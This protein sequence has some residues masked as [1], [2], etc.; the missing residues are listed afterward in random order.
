MTDTTVTERLTHMETE[1]HGLVGA[2]RARKSHTR[3]I[4]DDRIGLM[5][6]SGCFDPVV[7]TVHL[8]EAGGFRL[9][10]PTPLSEYSEPHLTIPSRPSLSTCARAE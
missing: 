7:D 6:N 10:V 1:W 9:C 3:H 2:L 5:I 8:P 4:P